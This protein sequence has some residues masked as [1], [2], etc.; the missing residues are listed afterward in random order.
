MGSLRVVPTDPFV[1]V[2]L[3]DAPRHRQNLPAGVSYPPARKARTNRPG[4]LGPGQP[5]GPMLGSPGPNVGYARMLAARAGAGLSLAPHERAA[6]A[7]A[8][9][10]EIAMK[11]AGQFG[12]APVK[13]DVDVAIALLGYD[14]SASAEFAARRARAVHDADAHYLP[15]RRVVDA[16]SAE[17]LGRS[18]N[19]VMARVADWR[20]LSE[21]SAEVFL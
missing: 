10:A 16:V 3:D 1:A 8:V 12:R 19:E 18:V 14:G 21:A 11:R 2:E 6:D 7:V 4:D 15:R 20:T 13:P 17:L 9:I 5:A